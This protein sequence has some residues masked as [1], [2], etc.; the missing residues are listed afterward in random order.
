MHSKMELCAGDTCS[1]E[2]PLAECWTSVLFIV[3]ALEAVLLTTM[4]TGW[5]PQA[6]YHLLCNSQ[7]T[8]CKAHLHSKVVQVGPCTSLPVV[9]CIGQQERR[10]TSVAPCVQC[11]AAE[12]LQAWQG[13]MLT[14][15]R[16]LCHTGAKRRSLLSSLARWGPTP[17]H[18]LSPAACCLAQAG[19]GTRPL[20]YSA[21]SATIPLSQP[22]SRLCWPCPRASS[23]SQFFRFDNKSQSHVAHSCMCINRWLQKSP[24]GQGHCSAPTRAAVH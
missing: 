11:D 15:R 7:S 19:A 20:P 18:H 6:S 17:V 3:C 4:A 13:L 9:A 22:A 23:V 10:R 1:K 12:L 21:P 14:A 5:Q 16:R 2:P 24:F 8:A